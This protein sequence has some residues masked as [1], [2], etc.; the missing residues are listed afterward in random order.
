MT[1][2]KL[3]FLISQRKFQI[4]AIQRDINQLIESGNIDF[5]K[6]RELTNKQL[7]F[8]S[9]MRTYVEDLQ[10][11]GLNEESKSV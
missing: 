7:N 5:V 4:S 10:I 11:I 3:R 6:V 2:R 8:R 1:P 9:Q